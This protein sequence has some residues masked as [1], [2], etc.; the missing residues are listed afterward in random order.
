M[1]LQSKECVGVN[2]DSYI[3]TKNLLR[4]FKVTSD[5]QLF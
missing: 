3:V 4:I 1:D 5:I 2:I